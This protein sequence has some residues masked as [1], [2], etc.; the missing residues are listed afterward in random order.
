MYGYRVVAVADGMA[1]LQAIEQ[2]PS[3]RLAIVDQE[4]PGMEASSS[5]AACVACAAA[6]RS[7]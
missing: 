5:P 1:G 4:M 6:T 2:D 3:I 7:R